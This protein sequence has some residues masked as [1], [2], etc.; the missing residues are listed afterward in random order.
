MART[1]WSPA[2]Q[3]GIVAIDEQHHKLI[4]L[5]NEVQRL[6]AESATSFQEVDDIFNEL[7]RYIAAHF[8]D[9]EALMVRISYEFL[10][11]H[12]QEHADFARQFA[13]HRQGFSHGSTDVQALYEW[14]LRW[15]LT[16]IAGSD[17][18][19]AMFITRHAIVV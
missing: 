14:L 3:I 17:S 9:E 11:Q 8:R 5:L 6:A 19:I 18:L 1:E 4:D 10:R 15:F 7:E 16:H 2:L 13:E 12:Q